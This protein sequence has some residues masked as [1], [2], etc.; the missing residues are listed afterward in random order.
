MRV[1][2]GTGICDHCSRRAGQPII[3]WW[4]TVLHP[5]ILYVLLRFSFFSSVTVLLNSLYL[6]PQVFF[7]SFFLPC[8][9][10][11]GGQWVN[12]CL[13][14]VAGRGWTTTD[15]KINWYQK[16]TSP[17]WAATAR[18]ELTLNQKCK[19]SYVLMSATEA[20][21]YWSLTRPWL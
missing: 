16:K 21:L 19:G 13:V 6:N 9:V 14:L 20:D 7:P 17:S 10:G 3:G 5:F 8:W 1:G 4:A 18:F 15:T 2:R 11:V 12:C